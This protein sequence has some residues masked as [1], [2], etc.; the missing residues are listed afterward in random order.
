LAQI[1]VDAADAATA[2]D[3]V[4]IIE[5]NQRHETYCSAGRFPDEPDVKPYSRSGNRMLKIK[6]IGP[7]NSHPIS[8]FINQRPPSGSP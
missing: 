2:S 3:I 4:T 8:A 6:L 1:Y 5:T 7:Y